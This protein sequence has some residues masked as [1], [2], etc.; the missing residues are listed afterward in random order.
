MLRSIGYLSNGRSVDK[1]IRYT[2]LVHNNQ[3]IALERKNT[4]KI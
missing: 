1:S 4:V 3:E 2:F